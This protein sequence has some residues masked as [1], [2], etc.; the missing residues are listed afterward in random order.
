MKSLLLLLV[1]LMTGALVAATVMSLTVLNRGIPAHKAAM[2]T[3]KYQT[4][5]ARRLIEGGCSEGDGTR[6]FTVM[7]GMSEDIE[8]QFRE[9]GFDAQLFGAANQKM[10]TALEQALALPADASCAQRQEAIT[11]VRNSCDSCHRDFGRG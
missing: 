4:G 11:A 7:R 2:V 10:R 6:Q 3:L 9:Q 8:A 1:G 5:E